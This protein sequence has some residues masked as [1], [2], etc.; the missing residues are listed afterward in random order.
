MTGIRIWR[1]FVAWSAIH[2]RTMS[3]T[4][5]SLSI[6]MPKG[7][8]WFQRMMF[9]KVAQGWV[10]GECHPMVLHSEARFALSNYRTTPRA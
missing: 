1:P 7:P 2:Q 9:W 6:Q 8:W 10:V 5:V 4:F 3:Q